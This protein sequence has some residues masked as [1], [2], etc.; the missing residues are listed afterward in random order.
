ME[1]KIPSAYK[2]NSTLEKAMAAFAGFL[3]CNTMRN[4]S[5]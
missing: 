2:G 1:L 5:A 3:K 4:T